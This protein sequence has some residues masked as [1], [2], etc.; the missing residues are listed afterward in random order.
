VK[1]MSI[2]ALVRG[3][4]CVQEGVVYVRAQDN[5]LYALDIE[6]G[7]ISWQLPLTIKGES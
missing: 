4:L 3:S 5:C 1:T 7:W 6:K 2:D